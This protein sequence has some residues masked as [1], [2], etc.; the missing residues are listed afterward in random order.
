LA[1]GRSSF[2]SLS[3]IAWLVCEDVVKEIGG[4]IS[5][6]SITCI[7][8]QEEVDGKKYKEKCES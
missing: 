5:I 4:W 6:E 1:E 8:E 2:S 7:L 3:G